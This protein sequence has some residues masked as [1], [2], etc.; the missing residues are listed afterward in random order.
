[1][2]TFDSAMVM[3]TLPN[4]EPTQVSISRIVTLTSRKGGGKQENLHY[5]I[6][7]YFIFFIMMKL[8]SLQC[9]NHLLFQDSSQK[10]L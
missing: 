1:M 2:G 6:Y 8:F 9:G 5:K 3:K 4:I 10:I 7:L